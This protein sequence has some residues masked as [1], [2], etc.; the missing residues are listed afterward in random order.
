MK[1]KH[2]IC[3]PVILICII[4]VIVYLMI[5][6][7]KNNEG[8][9]CDYA[10]FHICVQ[11]NEIKDDVIYG[12]VIKDSEPYKVKDEI[13][14]KFSNEIFEDIRNTKLSEGM[15][16]YVIYHQIEDEEGFIKCDGAPLVIE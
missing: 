6:D 7:Y 13:K 2:L 12:E 5:C 14:I 4:G 8:N 10:P 1:R 16:I 11:V 9:Y 3:I 15:K